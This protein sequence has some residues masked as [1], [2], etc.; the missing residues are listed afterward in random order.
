MIKIVFLTLT[1]LVVGFVIIAALQPA[2]FR[3]TRSILVS[4]SP[5]EA[6]SHINDLHK[7]QAISPY[8][9]LDL[10]AKYTFDGPPAGPGASLAWVGNAN[11]GEGRMTITESRPNE[12][13]GM[14]LDFIKPFASICTAEFS[15]KPKGQQ[16]AVTWSMTGRKI[17]V[18]KAIG[19]FM[20]MDKMIGSQFEEGLANLKSACETVSKT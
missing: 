1:A 18:T 14:K 17:F 9:R 12:M 3:V 7:W 10:A 4:T 19:L 15:F 13:V 6:F 2:E 16:T 11:V 8:V 5:A 20:N